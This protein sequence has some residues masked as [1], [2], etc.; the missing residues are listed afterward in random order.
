MRES[1]LTFPAQI[2]A[3]VC[4][5]SQLY[6]R[7]A[8]DTSSALPLFNS[9][10]HLT[11]L[12]STSPRIRE[13]M[14]M[15]GGLERLLRILHDFRLAPPPPSSPQSFYGLLPPSDCPP[16]PPPQLNPPPVVRQTRGLSI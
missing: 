6:D 2:K 8:L 3:C 16:R 11:S 14:T 7:R 15:D 12:T 4:I 1:D 10:T 13:I 9:F 5:T